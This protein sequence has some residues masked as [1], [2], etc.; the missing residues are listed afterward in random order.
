LQPV[1]VQLLMVIQVVTKQML[2]VLAMVS[3][4]SVV[5]QAPTP[6]RPDG[7][8]VADVATT[9][10]TKPAFHRLSAVG[11]QNAT[12]E[13]DGLG[14]GFVRQPQAKGCHDAISGFEVPVAPLLEVESIVIARQQA[15]KSP[16]VMLPGDLP[17]RRDERY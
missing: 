13:L 1:L 12:H 11:G 8:D 3:A 7:V 10:L 2:L 9:T 6:I 17:H 4:T 14:R 15:D 5:I 16:V